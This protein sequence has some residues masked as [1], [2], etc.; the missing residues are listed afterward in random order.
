M[1]TRVTIGI[2]LSSGMVA[3][4]MLSWD[5]RGCVTVH[6]LQMLELETMF[7]PVLFIANKI[8]L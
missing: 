5:G 8:I 6:Q 3:K 2:L 4:Y 7:I 1:T